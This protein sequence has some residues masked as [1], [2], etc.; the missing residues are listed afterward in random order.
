MNVAW[1]YR[2]H[3]FG[4][5]LEHVLDVLYAFVVRQLVHLVIQFEIST[6]QLIYF[7]LLQ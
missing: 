1:A 5:V 2:D 3:I 4:V 6:H 7:L